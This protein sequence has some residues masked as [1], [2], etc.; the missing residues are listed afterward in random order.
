M[1][2]NT[3]DTTQTIGFNLT[4]NW[5]IRAVRRYKVRDMLKHKDVGIAVR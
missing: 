2:I 4:G 3:M 1:T 5:A